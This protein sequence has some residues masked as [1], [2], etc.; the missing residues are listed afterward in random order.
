MNMCRKLTCLICVSL[1]VGA[2]GA[3][4]AAVFSDNFDTAHDYLVDGVAG[5]GW[6]GFLGKGPGETVD[7][8]NAAKDRPGQLFIRATNSWWEGAFSPQGPFLYK[9]VAG[10]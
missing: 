4:G 2:S 5:T 10:A 6:D 1:L 8:L 3:V 9:L 7:A